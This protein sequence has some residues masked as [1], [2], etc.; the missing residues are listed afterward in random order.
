MPERNMDH[1]SARRH[2]S[3]RDSVLR[4]LIKRVGPCTL[5]ADADG[6][7]VLAHSIVS[8][9]ISGKAARAIS[10]KLV[11]TLGRGGLR[12]RAIMKATDEALRAAGL[13]ASKLLSLRDL[14]EKCLSGAVPLKKL[15]G[16]ED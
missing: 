12:P 2:L 13:S 15:A 3:R 5:T 16:M 11:R 4:G 14:S 6:F 10:A 7:R 1:H 9:Q 8:Q